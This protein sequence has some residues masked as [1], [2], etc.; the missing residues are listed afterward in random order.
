MQSFEY[1]H[2]SAKHIN[3]SEKFYLHFFYPGTEKSVT[4]CMLNCYLTMGLY[5]K[6]NHFD[7]V[8]R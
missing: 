8:G 3:T 6:V 4:L 2:T 1:H 7:P 5:I